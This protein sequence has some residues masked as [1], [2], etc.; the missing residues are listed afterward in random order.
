ML[1]CCN[2]QQDKFD[3][4][5][6]SGAGGDAPLQTSSRED[7]N[8]AEAIK[9]IVRHLQERALTEAGELSPDAQFQLDVRSPLKR[10]E[11]LEQLILEICPNGVDAAA[12]S[13]WLRGGKSPFPE[14]PVKVGPGTEWPGQ[15]LLRTTPRVNKQKQK[16]EK[17]RAELEAEEKRLA[18]LKA[19]DN[20]AL[21]WLVVDQL[22]DIMSPAFA[23]G[24]A[25]TVMRALSGHVSEEEAEEVGR[26]VLIDEDRE[27]TINQHRDRRKKESEHILAALDH[28]SGHRGFEHALRRAVKSVIRECEPL[29]E[30]WTRSGRRPRSRTAISETAHPEAQEDRR[31]V[32]EGLSRRT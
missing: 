30:E 13:K 18:Y 5:R 26:L 32:L 6:G 1:D 7:E 4:S 2:A 28:F 29:R 15:T 31:E 23:M 22:I 14:R 25:W 17:L 8:G 16:I 24:P 27:E 10:R 19:H 12:W 9:L 11:L 21:H 3:M 20:A